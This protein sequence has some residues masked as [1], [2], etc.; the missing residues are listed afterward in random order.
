MTMALIGMASAALGTSLRHVEP[1][2]YGSDHI[3]SHHFIQ[4][5]LFQPFFLAL[6]SRVYL[7]AP[8]CLLALPLVTMSPDPSAPGGM[9]T[10]DLIPNDDRVSTKVIEETFDI[11]LP[12]ESVSLAT[13]PYLGLIGTGHA[14]LQPNLDLLTILLTQV[15]LKSPTLTEAQLTQCHTVG[16]SST[17]WLMA[18]TGISRNREDLDHALIHQY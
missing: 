8:L 2:Q 1:F 3:L 4:H 13:T 16:L 17:D 18:M 9:E 11:K 12:D 5:L 15:C 6:S 7:L 14:Y 10:D